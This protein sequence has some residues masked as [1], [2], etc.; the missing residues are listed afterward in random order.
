MI[1]KTSERGALFEAASRY[2]EDAPY[3]LMIP[4]RDNVPFGIHLNRLR[5]LAIQ[6]KE[7]PPDT[8]ICGVDL[9]AQLSADV[10]FQKVVPDPLPIT[11]KLEV[12]LPP[13]DGVYFCAD[14]ASTTMRHVRMRDNPYYPTLRVSHNGVECRET[15]RV[16][17]YHQSIFGLAYADVEGDV[18]ATPKVFSTRVIAE[19][20]REVFENYFAN[21]Y[22]DPRPLRVIELFGEDPF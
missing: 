9:F 11:V 10:N 15:P 14:E 17:G 3:D 20:N 4:S 16:L 18:L 12:S 2:R 6:H 19:W 21:M 7:L 5:N 1:E 8:L 22:G 13:D